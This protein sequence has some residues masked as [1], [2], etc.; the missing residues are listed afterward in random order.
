MDVKSIFLHGDLQEYIY[1]EQPLRYIHNDSNLVCDLKKSLYGLNRVPWVCYDKMDRILL[2]IDFSTYHF[3]PNIYTKKVG[4][5]I[6]ILILYVDDLTFTSSDPKILTHVKS[7]FKKKFEMIDLGHMH[8]LLHPQ[9]LQSN[10]GVSLPYSKY[11]F[12]LFL[13]IHMEDCKPT[14]SFF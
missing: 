2:D 3:D 8:Y 4:D 5:H 9:V 12:D 6:I 1:M 11:A 10:E 13:Y 14:P 7:S